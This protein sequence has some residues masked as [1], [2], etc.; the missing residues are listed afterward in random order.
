M[1]P[2]FFKFPSTPHLSVLG[3]GTVRDDKVLSIEKRDHFLKNKVSVEEKIDGANLGISFDDAGTLI[4]QNRGSILSKPYSGQWKKL[5]Q[6]LKY[7]KETFFDHLHAQYILFGEWCF[8]RHSVGYDSLPDYFLGFD[9][10]NKQNR[11][12]LSIKKRNERF[13]DMDI[14]AVPL[15]DQGI[16]SF[17]QLGELMGKSRF[18]DE[19]AEGIYLRH[20][21][22][23]WLKDRAKLVKPEF[24][25]TMEVHWSRKKITPNRLK[26]GQHY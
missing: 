11:R 24:I 23:E 7:R 12:F 14:S 20:D 4:I 5:E 22:G 1:N 9:I 15:I 8:A 16:F 17:Q 21:E 6:W 26:D 13:K 19:P 25:Q 18:S 2:L 3:N 10:F